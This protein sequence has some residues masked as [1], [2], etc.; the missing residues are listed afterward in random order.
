[1]SSSATPAMTT[2][3]DGDGDAIFGDEGLAIFNVGSTSPRADRTTRRCPAMTTSIPA[4]ARTPLFGGS[5]EDQIIGGLDVASDILLGDNGAVVLADGSADANDIFST[6][7]DSGAVDTITGGPGNDILIGGVP[8]TASRAK[9]TTTSSS[10][11]TTGSIEASRAFSRASRPRSPTRAATTPSRP[12]KVPTLRSAG[13][14]ATSSSAAPATTSCLATTVRPLVAVPARA[15]PSSPPPTRPRARSDTI[16]AGAATTCDGRHGLGDISRRQRRRDLIFGD[17]GKVE[18]TR[19]RPTSTSPPS[20]PAPPRAA[21][22]HD[23]RRGRR[24]HGH[25]RA[26]RRP[27]RP[28]TTR[29]DDLIGGH[30]VAGVRT[31]ATVS[32]AAPATT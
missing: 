4:K 13:S 6:D 29:D 14:A 23:P 30:N 5:G 8:V 3:G 18:F 17:H 32:T 22:R 7:P 10:A 27:H 11:T 19:R 2:L 21:P 28:A 31:R 16:T 25:R 24:R 9:E 1:M 12:A 26:G 15:G 20:T